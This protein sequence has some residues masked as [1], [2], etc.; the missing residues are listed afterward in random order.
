MSIPSDELAPLAASEIAGLSSKE[1]A[2]RR[3]EFGPNAVVEEQ[4]HPL[5]RLAR[6]F[7]APVPWM[8]E[9]T[10]VLQI[11]LGQQRISRTW[12]RTRDVEAMHL[13]R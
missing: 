5:M 13:S 7:W 9:A 1:A 3:V 8:L 12:G 6:H 4:V 10:I 11:I 2:S